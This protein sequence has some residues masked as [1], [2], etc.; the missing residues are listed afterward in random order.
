M[1]PDRYTL[2]LGIAALLMTGCSTGRYASAPVA[3]SSFA[4]TP[5]RDYD[6]DP[7]AEFRSNVG[8][9][10]PTPP[11]PEPNADVPIPTLSE[12]THVKSVG[13]MSILS[14]GTRRQCGEEPCTPS[15][16]CDARSGCIAPEQPCCP[17]QV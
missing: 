4:V 17:P 11:E 7:A 3:Q 14:H 15:E 9:P 1:R 16:N 6:A 8:L 5:V 2:L 13:L 12:D 10:A